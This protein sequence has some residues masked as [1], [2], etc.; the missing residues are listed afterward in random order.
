VFCAWGPPHQ[1][2]GAGGG[3]GGGRGRGGGCGG[4]INFFAKLG[5][6]GGAPRSPF[7][8]G[9]D[10]GTVVPVWKNGIFRPKQ[11]DVGW[12][13]GGNF[14]FVGWGWGPFVVFPPKGLL[15]SPVFVLGAGGGGGNLEL[16]V[17]S[18]AQGVWVFSFFSPPPQKNPVAE[19]TR[20]A[21]VSKKFRPP[22]RDVGGGGGD[23]F[24]NF[25]GGGWSKGGDTGAG[26]GGEG[27]VC[28]KKNHLLCFSFS[29]GAH[30]RRGESG[31]GEPG[32]FGEGVFISH[33]SGWKKW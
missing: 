15:W 16:F 30:K 13:Q 31:G 26:C 8:T 5:V 24:S 21:V 3:G 23:P 18:R 11:G 20:G 2:G 9:G 19:Q 32:L 29:G 7:F 25:Q 27:G 10:G 17:T 22:Q 14:F 6:G 12:P 33:P 4:T 1:T 28:K